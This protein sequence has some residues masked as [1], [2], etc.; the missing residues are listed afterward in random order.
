ML[1]CSEVFLLGVKR[2]FTCSDAA[3]RYV[4]PSL[5][6]RSSPR[7][8]TCF[9]GPSSAAFPTHPV[10]RPPRLSSRGLHDVRYLRPVA[11]LPGLPPG[12]S[13]GTTPCFRNACA[14]SQLRSCGSLLRRD[15]HSLGCTAFLQ[16]TR[17]GSDAVPVITIGTHGP[18]TY[19]ARSA[20]APV[21]I[22]R[23]RL[24]RPSAQQPTARERARVLP[25][26]CATTG[27]CC[28]CPATWRT[29]CW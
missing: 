23:A 16:V 9:R 8:S 10:G 27:P 4:L 20:Q 7:S 26:L 25:A 11:S 29:G 14:S 2:A 12:L 21:V 18:R 24:R 5:P 1:P 13:E 22:R 6:R 3:L 19:L 17:M 28:P 15:F